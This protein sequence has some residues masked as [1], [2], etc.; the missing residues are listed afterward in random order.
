MERGAGRP[1]Y[2]VTR[3]GKLFGIKTVLFG[4]LDSNFEPGKEL[5]S[6]SERNRKFYQK[7]IPLVS[8]IV[9]Q[10][11]YQKQ[12]LKDNYGREALVMQNIWRDVPVEGKAEPSD[13]V[14]VANF[15]PHKRPEWLFT[16]A[17]ALPEA[18]FTMVG[19]PD[20]KA[21]EFYEDIRQQANSITNMAFL[22]SRPFMETCDIISQSKVLVCSS[23]LEG[24]PNTF[25]QAWSYGLPVVSTVDPSGIIVKNNLG[26]V[27]ETEEELAAAIKHLL[28]DEKEYAE[29]CESVKAF[30]EKNYL[31]S[32]NYTRLME[33]I[34]K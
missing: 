19:G 17:Q 5:I 9:V 30:F 14:W 31:S 21:V 26:I 22:G 7:G 6:G 2:P 27:V 13:V 10:N 23:K 25:L 34:N 4:A 16:A 8:Y 29:K 32:D 12:T 15:R 24:F 33:Y 1:L 3:L 18:K 20:S 28:E 11:D